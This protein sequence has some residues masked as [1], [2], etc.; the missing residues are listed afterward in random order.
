MS[1]CDEEWQHW[2]VVSS[3]WRICVTVACVGE[4]ITV[5][6]KLV[7]PLTSI[8]NNTAMSFLPMTWSKLRRRRAGG[9]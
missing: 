5:S 7:T 8:I 1:N 6:A 3:G 9:L 2:C 4:R